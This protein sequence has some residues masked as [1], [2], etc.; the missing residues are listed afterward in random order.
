M[1]VLA[2]LQLI[3]PEDGKVDTLVMC[4]TRELAY[5]ICRE[6]MR[7]AKYMPEIKV[8]VYFGGIPVQKHKDMLKSVVPHIV[9]GTP[10]RIKQLVEEKDLD[11]S[12][13]KRV[14]FDEC[15][16][17]LKEVDM[18]G[19]VQQIFQKTPHNKQVMLFSATIPKEVRAIA[20]MFTAPNPIEVYVDD[21][22]KL[23]LHGLLQYQVRTLQISRPKQ[24]SR[25]FIAKLYHV[26]L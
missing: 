4:H 16:S 6:F 8:H 24:S 3:E 21:E 9:I 7:F 17:L 26:S 10:G 18:R 20:R 1:F 5:Q 25:F 12:H 14:I 23:T 19:T 22:S 2:T 11:V 13:V 15:D